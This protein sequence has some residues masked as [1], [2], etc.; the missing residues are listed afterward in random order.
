MR[1]DTGLAAVYEEN[2][3]GTGRDNR[4]GFELSPEAEDKGGEATKEKEPTRCKERLVMNEPTP[5]TYRML[6]EDAAGM[7]LCAQFFHI[8]GI[9]PDAPVVCNCEW[10]EGHEQT[11]DLVAANDLRQKRESSI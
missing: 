6:H 4:R 2:P 5:V 8:S 9:D 1:G 11:C 10:D 3:T 7:G